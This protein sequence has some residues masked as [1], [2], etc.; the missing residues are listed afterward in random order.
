MAK[1]KVFNKPPKTSRVGTS[2]KP[3]SGY[4]KAPNPKGGLKGTA[5]K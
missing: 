5:R 2:K 3:G 4:A 1:P